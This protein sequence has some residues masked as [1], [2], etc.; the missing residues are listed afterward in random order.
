M[1]FGFANAF[2][3][4]QE[5]MKKILSIARRRPM[6]QELISRGAQKE[7]HIDDRC[8]GTNN[9]EDNPIPFGE[10]FAVCKE[11]HTELK[12]EKCEFMHKTM[13]YLGFDI[14]YGW[15]TPVASMAKPLMDPKLRHEDAKKGLHHVRSFVG[16]CNFYRRHIKNFTYTSAIRMGLIKKTTTRRWA[17]Q[18]DQSYDQ[19]KYNVAKAK[20]L[21]VP[22]V[23]CKMIVVTGASNVG[24]GGTLFQ[25]QALQKKELDSAIFQ[26]GTDRLN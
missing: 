19:L 1:L 11:N 21:G 20:W 25:W 8:L 26:Q 17:P 5:L 3:F 4:F 2:A 22:R 15:W 16:M 18:E 10:F 24:S 14:G 13:Q 7:A 12:L 9:Q 6:V 23:Q